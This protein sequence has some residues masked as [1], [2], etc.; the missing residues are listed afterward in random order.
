MAGAN[1]TFKSQKVY[2]LTCIPHP[3]RAQIRLRKHLKNKA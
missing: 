3:K 2:K 1:Q